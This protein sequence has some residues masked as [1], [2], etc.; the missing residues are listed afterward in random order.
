[1]QTREHTLRRCCLLAIALVG[2]GSQVAAQQPA[3]VSVLLPLDHWTNT[4][5]RRVEDRAGVQLTDLAGNHLMLHAAAERLR[6]LAANPAPGVGTMARAYL[7]LLETE[8][9][10]VGPRTAVQQLAIDL[11]A[12]YT[13]SLA[14]PGAGFFHG[15]DWTG[16]TV[17]PGQQELYVGGSLGVQLGSRLAA[18]LAVRVSPDS[19]R[20]RESHAVTALGPVALWAGN[21]RFKFGP[22]SGGFVLGGNVDFTGGGLFLRDPIRLPWV[23]R[24]LGPFN[25]ET[26]LSRLDQNGRRNNP[27]FWAARGSI[28]PA[29]S[30]ILGLNR[31]SIFGGEGV[32]FRL[33]DLLE[34]I[35]GGYGG[36]KGEFEN[37]VVSLDARLLIRS[38]VQPVELYAE[39]AT[40]DGHG[41]WYKAPAITAGV[42]LPVLPGWSNGFASI[43]AAYM[44][45]KRACCN[46]HWYRNVYFRGSWS[47]DN[48]PMGH[49][50]GGHGKELALALGTDELAG[51]LRVR[52]RLVYRD[53]GAANIYSPERE[54]SS[55]GGMASVNWRMGRAEAALSTEL[56]D[57]HD[58][59][60]TA[61]RA[62]LRAYF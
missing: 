18:H 29:S 42:L 4:A 58:W 33:V 46:T 49:A 16:A 21:R 60:A 24:H 9:P 51:Q 62:G 1:V 27:W 35:A 47:K 50:L 45:P 17:L 30:L 38:Q 8:Y 32:R 11:L 10:G 28:Q 3:R 20:L 12:L 7:E 54:G 22:T 39:W 31:G 6:E 26:F 55:L 61:L 57:G 56:E 53:R 52:A 43:E 36:E 19:T 25:F 2:L 41:M 59:R 15:E 48:A 37:Q 13:D 14:A 40:D 5:L 34:M 44:G 23:F